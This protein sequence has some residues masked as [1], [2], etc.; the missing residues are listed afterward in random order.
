MSSRDHS[1][2]FMT[3]LVGMPVSKAT[4]TAHSEATA[5]RKRMRVAALGLLL[6]VGPVACV[7]PAPPPGMTPGAAYRVGAPD[8]LLVSILPEPV[9]ERTVTV[10]PDGQISIDLIGDVQASGLTTEEI[11]EEVRIKITRY[12]RDASVTVTVLAAESDTITLFGE[13]RNPGTFPILHDIRIAEAI[14]QLGGTTHFASR[15]YVRVIRS[16]GKKTEVIRVNLT[17]I[18]SGDLSTNIQLMSGDIIVVPP[19]TL[20][21]IGYFL[22]QVFFPFQPIIQTGGSYGAITN[23]PGLGGAP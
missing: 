10:R 15:R 18:Q 19:T 14:G 16:D 9:I 6:F 7:T 11:A 4:T 2:F 17:K 13:V 1:A 21:K 12:K 5:R 20:A 22:Q 3:M 8:E 23:L